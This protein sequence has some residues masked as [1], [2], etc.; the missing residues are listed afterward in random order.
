MIAGRGDSVFKVMPSPCESSGGSGVPLGGSTGVFSEDDSPA[1][2]GGNGSSVTALV[3]SGS[4]AGIE[5]KS[6]FAFV[7]PVSDFDGA[8]GGLGRG[9]SLRMTLR[10]GENRSFAV[11]LTA[12]ARV[13]MVTGDQGRLHKISGS[14]LLPAVYCGVASWCSSRVAVRLGFGFDFCFLEGDRVSDRGFGPPD[15]GSYRQLTTCP[16]ICPSLTL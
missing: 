16:F 9:S 14:P 13:V 7:D 4:S 8:T 15:L 12:G 3:V 1:G 5:I 2:T 6:F 11:L 10:G